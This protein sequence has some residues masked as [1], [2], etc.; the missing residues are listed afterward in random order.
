MVVS[1]LLSGDQTSEHNKRT[2]NTRTEQPITLNILPGNNYND[3]TKH[4]KWSTKCKCYSLNTQA[5]DL[6]K[7]KALGSSLF[8]AKPLDSF[9][10]YTRP[11]Y[12]EPPPEPRKHHSTILFW[13]TVLH[14]A[15]QI[16]N[17]K[18]PHL[19]NW[20]KYVRFINGK[21]EGKLLNV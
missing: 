19:R 18:S 5:S 3:A 4:N 10:T 14:I 16:W 8:P 7:Y 20:W 15:G 6:K 12:P 21:F 11:A 17:P 9:G 1:G 13:Q 2:D